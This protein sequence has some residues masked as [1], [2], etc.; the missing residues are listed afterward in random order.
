MVKWIPKQNWLVNFFGVFIFYPQGAW[1]LA[2]VPYCQKED[3]ICWWKWE[4]VRSK[5]QSHKVLFLQCTKG[6]DSR[7]YTM[8]D[9]IYK[10]T[11]SGYYL[12]A[13]QEQ[14]PT[15]VSHQNLTSLINGTSSSCR[16][17][18][19]SPVESPIVRLFFNILKNLL[20]ISF[21]H[22]KNNLILNHLT[23]WLDKVGKVWKF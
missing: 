18:H 4:E 7:R 6:P 13:A 15:F 10:H 3:P 16:P 21:S 22:F 1:K 9:C 19:S 5:Y 23:Q 20:N 14:F 8:E 17:F 2:E 12:K 11:K